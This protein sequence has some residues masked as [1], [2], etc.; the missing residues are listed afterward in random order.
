MLGSAQLSAAGCV[1]EEFLVRLITCSN[2]APKIDAD[3]R[4]LRI[5]PGSPGGL[6]PIMGALLGAVGGHWIYTAPTESTAPV[7]PPPT[8]GRIVL[9]PIVLS[10]Q[11]AASHYDRVSIRTLLWL[12]HYVFDTTYEPSFDPARSA[13]WSGYEAVNER[14]AQEIVRAHQNSSEEVVLVH[15]FHLMLVP[16]Y[17]AALAPHR[18][19]RLVYFHHVPWCDPD[20]FGIL[21]DR[22]RTAILESLLRCDVIGFHTR[23]WADAF[24]ACCERYLPAVKRDD[25][26]LE[27]HDHRSVVKVAPGP[28]DGEALEVLR[29]DPATT[30]WRERLMDR[31]RDRRPIVRVDRLDLWKN[32]IRGFEAFELL[33]ERHPDLARD[34]WFCAIVTPPRKPTDRSARYRTRCEETVARIN[35]KLGPVAGTGVEPISLVY[36]EPGDN[37]RHRAVAALEVSSVTLVN[38]TLDGLNMVAKEA[39]MVGPGAPLLLSVNA[40]AYEQLWPGVTPLHPFDIEATAEALL[41]GL[42]TGAGPRMAECQALLR[43]ESA[44]GWLCGLLGDPTPLPHPAAADRATTGE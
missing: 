21:P 24:L 8:A 42:S 19:S 31:S 36:P 17:V 1:T 16:H 18:R 12:F 28:I 27:Y 26:Q 25:S 3:T 7:A 4:E 23:R 2:S 37:S 29:R 9:T 6:L 38:P 41:A 11:L 15:D 34:L 39:V 35:E 32:V 33:L 40:G 44:T 43:R 14:F 30:A 20:Y 22:L 13:G 5:S 10:E